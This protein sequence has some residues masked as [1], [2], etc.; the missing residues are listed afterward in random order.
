MTNNSETRHKILVIDNDLATLTLLKE[1]LSPAFEVKACQTAREGIQSLHENKPDLIILDINLGDAYGIDTAK[2]IKLDPEN[3]EIPIIFISRLAT[4]EDRAASY[5]AGACDF[6]TKPFSGKEVLHKVRLNIKF[7]TDILEKNQLIDDTR[8]AAF[9]AM[10][11]SGEVGQVLHFIRDSFEC[12]TYERIGNRILEYMESQNLK[13]VILI[14]ANPLI[15]LSHSEDIAPLDKEILDR[16]NLLERIIDFGKRSIYNF[17]NISVLIKDMPVEDESLYGRIKDNI[18]LVL[19]AADAKIQ[20][21]N[22]EIAVAQHH[23]SISSIIESSELALKKI[24]QSFLENAK[25]NTAIMLGLKENIEETFLQFGLTEEQEAT[26]IQILNKAEVDSNA[27]YDSGLKIE[28]RI[29]DL[30]DKFSEL[31]GLET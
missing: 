16:L 3:K 7:Q 12:H 22:S 18:C 11:Q 1:Q 23:N 27:L 5:E 31:T 15:Y 14:K 30:V 8:K 20:A 2:M 24:E 28:E 25:K 13:S 21:I 9:A 26:I 6:I 10:A 29:G 17:E 4:Q 19:E